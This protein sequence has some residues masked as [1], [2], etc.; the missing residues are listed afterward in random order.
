MH[1]GRC[2]RQS[3]CPTLYTHSR[4]DSSPWEEKTAWGIAR[5]PGGDQRFW[6]VPFSLGSTEP[7][8][9]GLL[10][11]GMTDGRAARVP[12]G[13]AASYVVLAHF[14]DARARTTVAGQT[15][16]YPT[17]VVTAPG[18]HLA[19][20][21]IEYADGTEHRVPIRRRFEVNQVMAR[22]Q[23]AFLS[24]PHQ[25]LTPLPMRGPYPADLWGRYQTG[26]VYGPARAR[27]A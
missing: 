4:S 15:S 16:D 27:T 18:E 11:V 13:G 21:V 5:L 7:E 22:M 3:I 6:G 19:D 25:G 1:R 23:N 24:R 20:Y 26:A 9:P 14:C 12:L 8:A 17:P 10:V 2:S